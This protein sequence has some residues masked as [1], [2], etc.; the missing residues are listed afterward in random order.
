M[1]SMAPATSRPQKTVDDFM[2]LGDEV[3]AELIAGE[4]YMT[5]SP[6]PRHQDVAAN[7]LER[8]RPFV[9]DR[10]LGTVWIAPLD[11]H[12]P[13]GDIVEPDLLFV[14]KA[15]ESIIQDWIRG[16]PDLLIEIVSPSNPERDR[17]VKRDL[18]ARNGVG[19]YWIVDTEARAIEVLRLSGGTYAPAGYFVTGTALTTKTLP[20]LELPVEQVFRS[21]LPG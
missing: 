11:V 4:L 5:P 10:S 8:L 21:Q 2:A 18:Y 17:I 3:R 1:D 13:G 20:G 12:L 9:R 15:N 16:A 19:E 6:T 7:L 14:S